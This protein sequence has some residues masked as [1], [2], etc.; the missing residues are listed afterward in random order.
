M[1]A[2][3]SGAPTPAEAAGVT[4]ELEVAWARVI[5]RAF[6]DP[7]LRAHLEHDPAAVLSS[8][9]V[10]IPAGVNVA[11]DLRPTLASATAAMDREAGQASGGAGG[12]HP[13]APYPSAPATAYPSAPPTAYPS[14]PATAYPSAPATAYP[15]APAIHA[16]AHVHWV[17]YVPAAAYPSAQ[18][19]HAAPYPSAQPMHAAPYPSAQPMHV[20]PYP[21]AQ[22]MHA[23]YPSAQ[24]M[25]AI[26][27]TQR[28]PPAEAAPPQWFGGPPSGGPPEST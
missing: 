18:P 1:P 23:A 19:M 22:P 24:P 14:A 28:V 12:A 2:E 26:A 13:S 15:S 25:H 11:T 4:P 9:G 7:V 27:D 5:A 20:A 8:M 6:D 21:S 10:E 3:D 16:V 17:H